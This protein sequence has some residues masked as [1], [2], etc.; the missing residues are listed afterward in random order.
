MNET[1]EKDVKSQVIHP[2][3]YLRLL[4]SLEHFVSNFSSKTKNK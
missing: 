4:A 1:V 3:I 2:S